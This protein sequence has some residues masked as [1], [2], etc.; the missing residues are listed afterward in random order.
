[1]YFRTLKNIFS[2]LNDDIEI[3]LINE[4]N[5]FEKSFSKI[6]KEIDSLY[7]PN[8]NNILFFSKLLDSIL[9]YHLTYKQELLIKLVSNELKKSLTGDFDL[10][11]SKKKLEIFTDKIL[12]EL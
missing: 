9:E 1:M 6:K 10:E 3:E 8:E 11:Y 4:I 2:H 7:Y 12:K 5:N